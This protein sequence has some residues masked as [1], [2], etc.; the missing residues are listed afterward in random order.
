MK[1]G[2]YDKGGGGFVDAAHKGASIAG[3]EPSLCR[4]SNLQSFD[5]VVA[6]IWDNAWDDLT[7]S[8]DAGKVLIRV[9]SDVFSNPPPPKKSASGAY[10]LHILR[11][12]GSLREKDWAQ[13]LTYLSVTENIEKLIFNEEA[14]NIRQ[15]FCA[16]KLAYLPLLAILCQWYLVAHAEH[17][18]ELRQSE[19]DVVEKAVAQMGLYKLETLRLNSPKLTENI[20][21]PAVWLKYLCNIDTNLR[22]GGGSDVKHYE[23]I[24]GEWKQVRIPEDS[25]EKVQA[26]LQVLGIRPKTRAGKDDLNLLIVA[27]AYLQVARALWRNTE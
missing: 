7:K 3:L 10:V 25:W 8:S 4:L 12:I 11:P 26:L 20:S 21:K 2:L 14:S 22:E 18:I 9:S 17:R 24:Y 16:N 23:E 27:D 1:V 13:V 15:L 5:I 6:H 19:R